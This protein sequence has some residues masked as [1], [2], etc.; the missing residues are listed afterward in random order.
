MSAT[1]PPAIRITENG[2]YLVTELPLAEMTIGVDD[3]HSSW[4]WQHPRDYKVDGRYALCRCGNSSNKPF[5]DGTHA[6]IGFDGTETATRAPYADT[7][8]V[9]DGPTMDL[10]DDETLCAFARFC[11]GFG[12]VWKTVAETD[13]NSARNLLSYEASHCP[14]GRLVAHDK[15]HNHAAIE[16][17]IAPSVALVED[18]EKHVSGPIW[19]RGGVPI[20]SADG[21]VYERRNRV[22]LCRC[23][24]SKNKPFCDGTHAHVGFRAA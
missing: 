23:G 6:K 15:L 7:A 14:S 20:T 11:D 22:T 8:E 16:P 12:G 9:I 2:P 21:T 4:T 1:D 13:R 18:P 3:L 17:D 24:Q 10:H 19:V 5:C